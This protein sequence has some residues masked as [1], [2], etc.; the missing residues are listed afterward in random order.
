MRGVKIPE[1]NNKAIEA[2]RIFIICDGVK[3]NNG[4][5]KS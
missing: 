1:C 3:I 5:R 2:R 4:G